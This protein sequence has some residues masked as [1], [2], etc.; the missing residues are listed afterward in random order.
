MSKRKYLS[1]FFRLE[2]KASFFHDGSTLIQLR[3]FFCFS[4]AKSAKS[5]LLGSNTNDFNV[6]DFFFVVTKF[7][8]PSPTKD[9]SPL[10][11]RLRIARPNSWIARSISDEGYLNKFEYTFVR[12]KIEKKNRRV[13]TQYSINTLKV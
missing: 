7:I 3:H 5:F 13:C 1:Y 6:K 4:V 10:V 2:G 9:S 11:L 8:Q 12:H